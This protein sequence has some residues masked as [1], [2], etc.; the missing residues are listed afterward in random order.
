MHV[1]P[2]GSKL[3]TLACWALSRIT[4][5]LTMVTGVPARYFPRSVQRWRR[6]VVVLPIST[7]E[8]VLTE[9]VG[10]TQFR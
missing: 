4:R 7:T 8:I 6:R 10:V 1:A 9:C 5:A 2:M 3:Q